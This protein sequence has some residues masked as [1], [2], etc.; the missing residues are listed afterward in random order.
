MDTVACIGIHI[1]Q[2]HTTEIIN[3]S[4]SGTGLKSAMMT[5]KALHV[6]EVRQ[7]SY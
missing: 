5:D 4:K 2:T 7:H 3:K 6:K 1:P